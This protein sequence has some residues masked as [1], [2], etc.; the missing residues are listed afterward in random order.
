MQGRGCLRSSP[1]SWAPCC[2]ANHLQF[3]VPSAVQAGSCDS[4]AR[5]SAG[6]PTPAQHTHKGH[7]VTAACHWE[8]GGGWGGERP[9]AAWVSRTQGG[10]GRDL[11]AGLL[12]LGCTGPQTEVQASLGGQSRVGGRLERLPPGPLQCNL[13]IKFP[14]L[15][16]RLNELC[17]PS[18]S[19]KPGISHGM[20]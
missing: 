14:F 4:A 11:Q 2:L 16:Y 17:S 12:A 6:A 10:P 15:T 13:F 20:G 5:S 7:L 19:C 3:S 9:G 8:G 1:R 18:S